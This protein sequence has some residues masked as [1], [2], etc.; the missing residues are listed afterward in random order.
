MNSI[1]YNGPSQVI[2]L[3]CGHVSDAAKMVES[4]FEKCPQCNTP[5][6]EQPSLICG[7]G[8]RHGTHQII[9]QPKRYT[10]EIIK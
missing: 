3:A 4:D 7:Q 10:S 1:I 2:C 9:D 5:A 6:N 8:D